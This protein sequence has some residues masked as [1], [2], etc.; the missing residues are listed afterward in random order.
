MLSGMS[1]GVTV[2]GSGAGNV[3]STTSPAETFS[4]FLGMRSLTVTWPSVISCAARDREMVSMRAA[5]N[6]SRRSP[7]LSTTSRCCCSSVTI[8]LL[9]LAPQGQRQ[10]NSARGYGN[11]S[12][13]E[14]GPAQIADAY[15]QEVNHTIF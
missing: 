6:A 7:L 13:V 4:L 12:N 15:V 10:E 3:T 11:V 9:L 1:S 8:D 2:D 14:D 5:R